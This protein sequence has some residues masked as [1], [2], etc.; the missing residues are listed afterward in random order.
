[1]DSFQS[2]DHWVGPASFA[3]YHAKKENFSRYI[4]QEGG[5]ANRDLS[6]S[7]PGSLMRDP[8]NEVGDLLE[9]EKPLNKVAQSRKP[10]INFVQ[11]AKT[12]IKALTRLQNLS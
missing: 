11:K 4:L 10:A 1:M 12:E 9:T 3:D 6:T 7:F 5:I 2:I 8:G